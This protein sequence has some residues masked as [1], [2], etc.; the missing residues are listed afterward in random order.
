MRTKAQTGPLIRL[1]QPNVSK[2]MALRMGQILVPV[3]LLILWFLGS[4]WLGERSLPSPVS[5][6]RVLADGLWGD[7]F[8][9]NNLQV[10][11]AEQ[12]LGFL[13]AAVF[14]LT[15]GFILG[16]NSF[17]RE[18]YE[19]VLLSVYTIPKVTLFPV[20][21]FMFGIA[22][23]SKIAFGMF[24]G[25]FPI[26]ILTMSATK[27][28]K[29]IYL[30]VGKALRLRSWRIFKEIIFPSA[31]PSLMTG[32]RLG[33][34]LCFLGVVLGEMFSSKEGLG[35]ILMQFEAVH[36]MERIIA[37]VLTLAIIALVVNL[38][39]YAVEWRLYRRVE[40]A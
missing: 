16:I 10:T 17:L 35:L 9:L 12:A 26:A 27:A 3:V 14:G 32:L 19:P 28:V 37:I 33:F 2:T 34:N 15:I 8:I 5:T 30:K 36:H 6:F 38:A 39:F 13:W 18:A 22:M 1:L 11:L 40:T 31:L 4:L 23:E 29:E 7:G 20:F 24:H 25:V 21:L